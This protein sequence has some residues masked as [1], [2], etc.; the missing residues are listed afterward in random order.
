MHTK[1]ERDYLGNLGVNGK[2]IL[3]RIIKEHVIKMWSGFVLQIGKGILSTQV[4]E[5][6]KL[7]FISC[8]SARV[9]LGFSD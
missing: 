2:T 6:S 9:P 4:T 8:Q 7:A 1:P 3:K 5:T